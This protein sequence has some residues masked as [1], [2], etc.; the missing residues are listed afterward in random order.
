[1]QT[2]V[3]S[4]MITQAEESMQKFLAWAKQR[5]IEFKQVWPSQKHALPELNWSR[6]SDLGYHFGK[7]W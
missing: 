7:F 3:E 2:T 1:M 6:V 4:M 5:C